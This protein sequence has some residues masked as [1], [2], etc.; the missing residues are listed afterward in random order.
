MEWLSTHSHP[1]YAAIV[2]RLNDSRLPEIPPRFGTVQLESRSAVPP[3]RHPMAPNERRERLH[4]R[5]TLL[6]PQ[7][8]REQMAQDLPSSQSPY[9]GAQTQSTDPYL[10]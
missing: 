6:A 7:E 1:T 4:D 3:L 5:A 2:H 8:H 9:V 10:P